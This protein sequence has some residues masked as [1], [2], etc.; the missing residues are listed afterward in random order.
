MNP[1]SP[2]WF[3]IGL[4]P[5]DVPGPYVVE[6]FDADSDSWRYIGCTT[7]RS[8]IETMD[9]VSDMLADRGESFPIVSA[10]LRMMFSES[11]NLGGGAK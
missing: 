1:F 2:V 9:K 10:G 7:R 5:S 11:A 6:F 3:R 8:M 4:K